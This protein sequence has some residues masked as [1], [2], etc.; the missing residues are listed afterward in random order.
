M[1]TSYCNISD[2]ERLTQR[3]FA[4]DT[5]P[6]DPEVETLISNISARLNGTAQAAG[7]VV[8]VTGTTA[9]EL[10]ETYCMYGVACA[11]WHAGFQSNAAPANVEYWCVEYREFLAALRKGEVELPLLTPESDI[12]PAFGFAQMPPR[13]RLWT[14]RDEPLA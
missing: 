3:K 5:R 8:P 10:M 13:D 14:G 2:V 9:L 11:A 7:Y 4:L 1:P 6:T 12:D